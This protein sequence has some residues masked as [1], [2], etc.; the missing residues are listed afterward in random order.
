MAPRS[1]DT[2]LRHSRARH[3][4]AIL[5]LVNILLAIAERSIFL[6]GANSQ[7]FGSCAVMKLSPIFLPWSHCFDEGLCGLLSLRG[8]LFLK[9]YRQPNWLRH[10][11]HH[12]EARLDV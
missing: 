12:H 8:P 1:G 4:A 5:L 9:R 10:D 2:D 3:E 7:V 11:A 6:K